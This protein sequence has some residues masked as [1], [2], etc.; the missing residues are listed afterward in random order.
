MITVGGDYK[1]VGG[2]DHAAAYSTGWRSHMETFFNAAQ[3]ISIGSEKRAS[4]RTT[5]LS[6]GPNGEDISADLGITW[7]HTD[8]LNLNAVVALGA[9]S[10]W[11]A[12]AKGTIAIAQFISH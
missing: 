10:A 11:G 2:G 4:R 6:V 5:L 9:E 1:V 3:R 8:A 12:G 7:K